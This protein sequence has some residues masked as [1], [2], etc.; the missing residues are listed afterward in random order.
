MINN[1]HVEFSTPAEIYVIYDKRTGKI[2]HVHQVYK[3]EQPQEAAPDE[4]KTQ[5]ESLMAIVTED[6]LT[7]RSMAGV[8]AENLGVLVVT[9]QDQKA[10]PFALATQLVDPKSG[11]L[12]P[13]PQIKLVADR[14]KLLGNGEDSV[15][16]NISIVNENGVVDKSNETEVKVMS[17]RG[18]LSTEGGIVKLKHG[19]GKIQLKSVAETASEVQVTARCV[20][21]RCVEGQLT[22]EFL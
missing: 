3:I 18:K 14:T 7:M 1:Q 13:K 17:S 8:S 5:I 16:I 21:G 6:R 15:D 12:V 10:A 20:N 9:D 19:L 11:K 4:Q 22:L 2:V